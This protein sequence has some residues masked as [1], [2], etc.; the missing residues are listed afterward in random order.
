MVRQAVRGDGGG[1]QGE[2]RDMG[3][4]KGRGWGYYTFHYY[5]L[6]SRPF[7]SLSLFLSF[8]GSFPLPSLSLL[9]F[10]LRAIILS[11]L[12]NLCSLL[13]PFASHSIPLKL[14]EERREKIRNLKREKN[15]PKRKQKP[16]VRPRTEYLVY[17]E[18]FLGKTSLP[19]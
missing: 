8:F 16:Q 5:C 7:Q 11:S 15:R 4:G 3:K 9:P 2:G 12:S 14:R 13:F 1:E 6:L 10:Y 18:T 17:R 19:G